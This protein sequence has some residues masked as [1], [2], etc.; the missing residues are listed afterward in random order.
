MRFVHA[1]KSWW[2]RKRRELAYS[3]S[4]FLYRFTSE[5]HFTFR[6]D[7][8]VGALINVVITCR[9]TRPDRIRTRKLIKPPRRSR[10]FMISARAFILRNIGIN[11]REKYLHSKRFKKKDVHSYGYYK[12]IYYPGVNY[13]RRW[14]H[15]TDATVLHGYQNI[16]AGRQ[17]RQ[18]ELHRVILRV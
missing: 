1:E 17:F 9:I 3:K 6:R 5:S 8:L 18:V 14:V 10:V 13:W 7:R 11:A 4:S 16:S 2:T 12:N 15:R